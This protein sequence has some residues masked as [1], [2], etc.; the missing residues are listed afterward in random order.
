MIEKKET[1]KSE[2]WLFWCECELDIRLRPFFRL[3][4]SAWV[5]LCEVGPKVIKV[6]LGPELNTINDLTG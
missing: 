2:L 6:R 4:I 3:R 1:K 5:P